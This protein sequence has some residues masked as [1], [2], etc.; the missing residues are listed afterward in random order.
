MRFEGMGEFKPGATGPATILEW[1]VAWNVDV[2]VF[3]E[4]SLPPHVL[5]A[6][7]RAGAAMVVVTGSHLVD[8]AALKEGIY[9]GLGSLETP[10]LNTAVCPVFSGGNENKHATLSRRSIPNN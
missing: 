5:P 4:Y 1:C 7:A 6:V 2:V 9:K 3:P 8:R 10:A